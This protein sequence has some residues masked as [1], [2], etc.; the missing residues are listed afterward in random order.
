M[1][2]RLSEGNGHS[3]TT[4]RRRFP[5]LATLL[6]LD[7]FALGG[8]VALLMVNRFLNNHVI[9]YAQT[10]MPAASTILDLLDDL[11]LYLAGY[12]GALLILLLTTVVAWVWLET[13]SQ[14][15]RYGVVLLIFSVVLIV[16]IVW[17]G[18]SRKTSPPLPMT[19][20]PVAQAGG[21][22]LPPGAVIVDRSAV[23]STPASSIST[24]SEPTPVV[25][26]PTWTPIPAPTDTPVPIS[27]LSFDVSPSEVLPGE[28]VTLTWNALAERVVIHKLDYKGR[29][30][31]PA[32]TVPLSG[33]LVITDYHQQG[34][35][36]GFLL[37]ACAGGSC[38]NAL[39]SAEVTC[40]NIWFFSDPPVECPGPPSHTTIVA[41][42]FERGLM[43]WL[44]A[45]DWRP[46]DGVII[47]YDEL[48]DGDTL[49][50]RRW[51][52]M[53]DDW[54]PS[55]PEEDPGIVPPA[56][57]YEPVRGFGKLWRELSWVREH[58]GWAT[59]EEFVVGDGAFQC[60]WGPYSRC[61]VT[62]PNDMV[63]VL[64]PEMSGWFIWP[65]HPPAL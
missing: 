42:H 23:G 9:Y 29:L 8:L 16:G 4:H 20:T 27:I 52:M 5:V 43:L 31:E 37:S 24:T 22:D 63:Y 44:E 58:L 54:D 3:G 41:Q 30:V 46:S 28:P 45:A 47:L 18:R 21:V 61:Y 11:L 49:Q 57:Y 26:T 48:Y 13:R 50:R 34:N 2:N 55:M 12:I 6:A 25:P 17:I 65:E 64:E 51:E 15:L 59:D 14:L 62:G 53:V 40:T 36:T 56:G 10:N 33:S 35:R 1:A 38:D 32:F 19:P 60:D 39:V 7:A